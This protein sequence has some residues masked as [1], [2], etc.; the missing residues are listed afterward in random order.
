MGGDRGFSAAQS[1]HGGLT[2]RHL[3]DSAV[4]VIGV[5]AEDEHGGC[6][7]LLDV[8]ELAGEAAPTALDD[9]D[10]AG[11][12]GGVDEGA[13]GAEWAGEGEFGVDGFAVTVVAEAEGLRLY[14][15]RDGGDGQLRFVGDDLGNRL[16]IEEGGG[17][18]V[19]EALGA[20]IGDV[21]TP[22]ADGQYTGA[23]GFVIMKLTLESVAVVKE[24]ASL[25]V[26]FLIS[27]LAVV[28]HAAGPN[29]PPE[30]VR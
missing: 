24:E 11:E 18:A 19:A 16:L 10:A 5:E 7:G 6:A 25:A 26:E 2:G 9:G 23:G 20:V 13:V 28:C 12:G 21:E 22:L 15:L 1:N 4:L 8:A 27:E 3:E 14:A 17:R 29:N 30:A